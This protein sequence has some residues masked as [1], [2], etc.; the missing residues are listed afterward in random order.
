[1]GRLTKHRRLRAGSLSMAE[2]SY[3]TSEVRGSGLECQAAMAQ[4]RPRGATL[5]P[6]SGQRLRLLIIKDTTLFTVLLKLFQVWPWGALSIASEPPDRPILLFFEHYLAP[7]DGPGPS[8]TL[9]T[10]ALESAISPRNLGLFD[11]MV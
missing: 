5:R 1:M 3:P 10:P 7:Q 4:E 6:R 2:R 11:R 9:P 8:C